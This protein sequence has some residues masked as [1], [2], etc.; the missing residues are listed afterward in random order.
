[1]AAGELAR[2]PDVVAR[3]VAA[4]QPDEHGLCRGCT[5]PGVGTPLV[6]WPCGLHGLAAEA[7]QV[8]VT[9]DPTP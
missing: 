7:A 8:A 3:L 5:T 9:L 2:M 6:R 1:M 4:H